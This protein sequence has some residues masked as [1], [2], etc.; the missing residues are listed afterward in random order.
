MADPLSGVMSYLTNGQIFGVPVIAFIFII[1]LIFAVAY[2]FLTKKPKVKEFKPLDLKKETKKRYNREYNYFGKKLG[3]PIYDINDDI[4]FGWVVGYMKVVWVEQF[5]RYEPLHQNFS[6]EQLWE[7]MNKS[8]REVYQ[9][10]YDELDDIQKK[11]ITALSKEELRAEQTEDVDSKIVRGKKE[12]SVLVPT[13]IYMF[14]ITRYSLLYRIIATITN[15]GTD[16]FIFDADQVD[17]QPEKLVT[18]ANYERKSANNIFVFS[19]AGKM[20]VQDMGYGIERENVWQETANQIPRAVHFDTEASK[21]L[22]LRRE[23]A[24]IESDKYKHQKEANE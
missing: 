10:P 4:P 21:Q 14:K 22:I 18:T 24:K 3:K 23:D 7:K 15:L 9:K 6:K 16:Y 5:K 13:P 11:N 17:F 1:V 12:V 19:K 20:M 2:M 8:A